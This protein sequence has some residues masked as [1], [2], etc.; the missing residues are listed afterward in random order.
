MLLSQT[1]IK[2]RQFQTDTTRRRAEVGRRKP[3]LISE[4]FIMHGP[5]LALVAG[6]DRGFGSA[7]RKR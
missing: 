1:T 4:Q 7:L 5:E 3:R 6:A 2:D